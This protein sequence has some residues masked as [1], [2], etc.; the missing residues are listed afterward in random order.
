[1]VRLFVRLGLEHYHVT[2]TLG[3]LEIASMHKLTRKQFVASELSEVQEG[4]RQRL[5]IREEA[6]QQN[7]ERPEVGSKKPK[8]LHT[9]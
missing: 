2:G 5:A 6:Q 8:K 7:E 1:V 3:K 9:R 4:A